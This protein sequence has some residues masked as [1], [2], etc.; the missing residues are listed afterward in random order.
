MKKIMFNDK[1]GL[2]EA[3]LSGRKTMTRRIVPIGIYNQTDWKVVSEGNYEAVSDG[4][5][6]WHD[7]RLCGQY[8]IGEDVAV[9]QSYRDAGVH[10]IY[11]PD[12]QWGCTD[13]MAGYENKMFVRADLMPHR[14]RITDIKVER[15][16]DIS[17]EDCLRE[18]I[19]K[20]NALPDAL[21]EDRYKFISYAYDATQDKHRKR[22]WFPTPR[23][24]FAALIDKV[25]KRG[26]WDSNPWVW[27]YTFEVIK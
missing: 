1:Y 13:Q 20:H 10:F 4:E 9:A 15:L 14:I 22:K 24:A 2:T 19:Y 12:T 17:E 26:T 7:I 3:V 5:G 23:E 16:Q 27:A 18:G 21:G 25:C 8:Q 6:Y 11:P